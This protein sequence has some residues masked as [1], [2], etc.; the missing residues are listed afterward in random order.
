M[1]ADKHL[2]FEDIVLTGILKDRG[3]IGFA[4]VMDQEDTFAVQAYIINE[5]HKLHDELRKGY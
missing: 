4:D 5:A 2:I 1:T 3:M